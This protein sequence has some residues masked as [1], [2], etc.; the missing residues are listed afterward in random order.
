MKKFL[1][2][3]SQASIDEDWIEGQT[4]TYGEK[5]TGD[6][7]QVWRALKALSEGE[8]R[9]VVLSISDENGFVAWKSL[10]DNFEPG[11]ASKQGRVVFEFGNMVTKPARNPEELR[12]LIVEME[13]KMKL[14]VEITKEIISSAHA[15]GV[16]VGIMDPLTRQHTAQDHHKDFEEL[17]A[18]VKNFVN[19]AGSR[20]NSKATSMEIGAVA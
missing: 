20:D 17:K 4:S 10:G 18:I 8:A 19:N 14:V 3:A 1:E 15:K 9:D 13:K 12:T 5:V 2:K 16:L 11:L 6:R 7:V